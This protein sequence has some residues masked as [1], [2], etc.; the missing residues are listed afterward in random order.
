[1][2]PRRHRLLIWTLLGLCLL[3]SLCIA[4]LRREAR[5]HLTTAP[6]PPWVE[7]APSAPEEKVTLM[8]AND[9]DGSLTPAL[10]KL[11][12]PEDPAARARAALEALF[13]EYAR[14][15]STHPLVSG[16]P[17]E[18]IFVTPLSPAVADAIDRS[19]DPQNAGGPKQLAVVDF[20]PEF[21]AGH[22][23]G[24][25]PETL[26]LLSVIGT[27][28]AN[29]PAIAEVRFLVDGKTRNTLAGHADLTR[30]YLA[31]EPLVRNPEVRP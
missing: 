27:L 15:R 21:A 25:E 6:R 8:I 16:T 20:T 23:S 17:I 22:P 5:I 10:V 4:L 31:S 28:H 11:P 24:I 13:A 3:L 2:T 12:L 9:A 1:M 30:V 14:P 7:P 19:E 18:D 29:Q 26:T